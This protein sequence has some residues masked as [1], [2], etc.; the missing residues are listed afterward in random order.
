MMIST[1]D[2][3]IG[4]AR[5]AACDA[6]GVVRD[7]LAN[8]EGRH[9]PLERDLLL[10]LAGRLVL[11]ATDNDFGQIDRALATIKHLLERNY[12]HLATS[13]SRAPV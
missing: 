10:A 12:P 9:T 8:E 3:R 1:R 11:Q 13:H 7:S 5:E 2:E 6:L 4:K